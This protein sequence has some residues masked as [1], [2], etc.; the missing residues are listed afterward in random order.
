[1]QALEQNPDLFIDKSYSTEV[2]YL[3]MTVTGPLESKEA[4]QAMCYA[5]PY[6]DVINGV[7]KGYG[8][9]AIGPVAELCRGFAK[10]TLSTNDRSRQSESAFQQRPV[11]P[12][13][14]RISLTE[15]SGDQ[16]VISAVQ[17]FQANLDK[18]GIKLNIKFG[19]DL[20]ELHQGII[21]GD[22]PPEERPMVMPWFWWPDYN[23][24]WDHLDPQ[25]RCSAATARGG[26]NGGF[27]CNQQVDDLMLEARGR[28]AGRR[29]LQQ[30][31]GQRATDSFAGASTG[32]L[33]HAA[34]VDDRLAQR[35]SR[36][37]FFN[38]IYIGTYDYYR[39][40]RKA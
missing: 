18:I 10:E 12:K 9:R 3:M 17:L 16:N 33:L 13:E 7:Y 11:W 36:A 26:T 38:P 32:G 15:E 40:R 30:S 4:R 5:F 35:T 21:F 25:V 27:Y 20:T 34:N 6:D 14:P 23:D 22:A 19:A 1:M 2:D 29:D 8:K 31:A 37:F 24:A 28:C 39:L